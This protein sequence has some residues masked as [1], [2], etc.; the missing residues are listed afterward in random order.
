MKRRPV[1]LGITEKVIGWTESWAVLNR[2]GM[3]G[4]G[5][6]LR[7]GVDTEELGPW[8]GLSSYFFLKCGLWGI[9]GDS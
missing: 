9:L 3:N 5:S 7:K 4:T 2:P 1:G 6:A 8:G